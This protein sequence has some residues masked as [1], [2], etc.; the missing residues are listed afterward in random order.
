MESSRG[1]K[2]LTSSTFLLSVYP[3]LNSGS[4]YVNHP[5][6]TQS[7]HWISFSAVLHRACDWFTGSF[8]LK[9]EW[10]TMRVC[11]H[12]DTQITCLYDAAL[13]HLGQGVREQ[14]GSWCHAAKED[15]SE[16]YSRSP[17]PAGCANIC[18]DSP[19][20]WHERGLSKWLDLGSTTIFGK[21]LV[22]YIHHRE[23]SKAVSSLFRICFNQFYV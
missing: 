22:V 10:H 19:Q 6:P 18:S 16:I 15:P 5:S 8:S 23:A 14:G 11:R 2:T 20:D 1:L 17:C 13:G 4:M 7:V 3:S 21:I 12:I 9:L